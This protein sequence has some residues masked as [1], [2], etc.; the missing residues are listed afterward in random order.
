VLALEET[1][2][3]EKSFA[4]LF[5]DEQWPNKL[6]LGAVISSV[7]ILNFAWTGYMV[8]ILRNVINNAPEPLPTWDDVDRKFSDGLLLFA[9]GVVYALPVLIGLFLPLSV[10][11]YS[12][13]ASGEGN[14]QDIGRTITE[15]GGVL[16]YGLLCGFV[17]YGVGLSIIYPAILVVYARE[18]SFASC[19]KL[20]EAFKMISRNIGPFFTAWGLS[21]AASLGVGLI[22]GFINLVVGWVP[23]LGWI[24]S[25]ALS[26][27]SGVYLAAVY[28]YLFGQ[29][30][31]IA[32]GQNQLALI[33]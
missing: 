17:L 31:R 20:G 12:S 6:G 8:G 22:V 27:G 13:L 26:F 11:A 32:F 28:A 5:E 23:C 30:G 4:F 29:F 21:V 24:I 3:V 18:G 33:T 16:F 1:M 19:F 25:L 10:A 14:L 7:P 15:A 2:D 9:A